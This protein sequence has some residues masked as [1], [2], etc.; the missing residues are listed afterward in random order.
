ML[1]AQLREAFRLMTCLPETIVSTGVA[2]ALPHCDGGVQD[3][4]QGGLHAVS[5]C[6]IPSVVNIQLK[7][8]MHALNDNAQIEWLDEAMKQKIR[9]FV[10][11]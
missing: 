2:L 4:L 11:V 1:A 10:K 3:D 6:A 5:D 7:P 9:E 8:L